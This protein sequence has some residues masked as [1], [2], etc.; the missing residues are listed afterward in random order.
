MKRLF[1]FFKHSR[2]AKVMVIM[3]ILAVFAVNGVWIAH[4]DFAQDVLGNI[5]EVVTS[6]LVG[7]ET[8][9]E[10]ADESYLK[11]IDK[12]EQ[13]KEAG[14]AAA[15]KVDGS[16][17]E[18]L[19]RGAKKLEAGYRRM[20]A[21]K[22]VS[23]AQ[24]T[25]LEQYVVNYDDAEVVLVLYDYL[26]DNHFTFGDLDEALARYGNG[27]K[28]E[29]ILQSYVDIQEAIEP[30]DYPHEEIERLVT[31]PGLSTGDIMIAE[32]LDAHGSVPFYDVINARIAGESWE[33]LALRYNLLNGSAKVRTVTVAGS[34]VEACREATGLTEEEAYEKVVDAKK[35]GVG[36][37]QVTE[38]VQSGKSMGT[39]M[40]EK[41][42]KKLHEN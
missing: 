13:Q 9:A 3:A 1:G 26:Y 25:K 18:K 40:K 37:E 8:E 12:K 19:N 28:I 7:G 32:I 27:E 33:T 34:E 10:K 4:A 20:M 24:K 6:V 17:K 39:A 23:T 2:K 30:R 38:F 5:G 42:E 21:E 29:D 14:A 11:E 16:T 36:E 35:A 15:I 41:A 22:E 31:T